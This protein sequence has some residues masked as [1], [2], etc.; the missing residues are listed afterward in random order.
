MK[1]A[2]RTLKKLTFRSAAVLGFLTTLFSM[3]FLCKEQS[4]NWFSNSALT[5]LSK[6]ADI[7]RR[8]A[9]MRVNPVVHRPGFTS[10][11]EKIAFESDIDLSDETDLPNRFGLERRST[12]FSRGTDG[13]GVSAVR[14][15][16]RDYSMII[17]ASLSPVSDLAGVS[18]QVVDHSLNAFFNQ[19][20]IKNTFV[21]RAAETVE[22]K[23][24]AEV[25]LGG[26]E[27][28]S[29]KHNI[30]FQVKATES[31]ASMEYRGLTNC[32]FSYSVASQ[33]A[34]FEIFEPLSVNS[35]LV[36][37]HSDAPSDRRDVLSLRMHW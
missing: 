23:L 31:K 9:M 15:L 16:A 28:E 5:A 27:P 21:G 7:L 2:S 24:K 35:N 11:L 33:K 20:S 30:K 18:M 22:K 32:D 25:E 37:T 1:T 26:S 34:N 12:D 29:Q 6:A 4:H 36:F 13:R 14:E 10:P 8:P 19:A 17:P 3:N